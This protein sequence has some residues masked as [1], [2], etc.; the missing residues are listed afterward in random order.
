MS[1][2]SIT[3]PRSQVDWSSVKGGSAPSPTS[4][5]FLDRIIS[6]IK[7]ILGCGSTPKAP[8]I[9]KHTPLSE[10]D[11]QVLTNLKT[12]NVCLEE[13]CF[14]ESAGFKKP[15]EF[16]AKLYGHF[17]KLLM[18]NKELGSAL[19]FAKKGLALSDISPQTRAE[20]LILKAEILVQNNEKL[21]AYTAA[22][23]GLALSDISSQTRAELLIL[24]AE[25]HMQ[26]REL[27]EAYHSAKAGLALTDISPETK[28]NL[29]IL[30]TELLMNTEKMGKLPLLKQVLHLQTFR[31]RQ[32]PNSQT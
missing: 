9:K 27:R 12:A 22:C 16:I 23:T 13:I 11:I 14:A 18:Q 17:A 28:A 21:R 8:T 29:L 6:L 7:R 32:K 20:L 19:A 24:K 10:K 3:N 2:L 26:N 30:K 5:S 1:I 15:P 25:L 31:L 4:K